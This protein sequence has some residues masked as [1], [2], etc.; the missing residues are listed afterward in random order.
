[1]CWKIC[2]F[3]HWRWTTPQESKEW[4]YTQRQEIWVRSER[5]QNGNES[6]HEGRNRFNTNNWR[7][8]KISILCKRIENSDGVS[9][10]ELPVFRRILVQGS[11]VVDRKDDICDIAFDVLSP[12]TPW[13]SRRAHDDV[14]YLSK[15]TPMY[16]RSSSSSD[17]HPLIVGKK[18]LFRRFELG[19]GF[20][21]T[22]MSRKKRGPRVYCGGGIFI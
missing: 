8:T 2:E 7:S 4:P 19:S 1:M 13:Q 5:R 22:C 21:T 9:Y 18:S 16:R 3:Y 12:Q 6:Y 17:G 11:L 20:V 10:S 14:D 15:D